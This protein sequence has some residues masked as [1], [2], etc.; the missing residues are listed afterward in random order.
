[1]EEYKG[2]QHVVRT[3][4]KLPDYHLVIAGRG[5]YKEELER[6]A[7][8]EGVCERVELL[9][10]VDDDRLPKLYVGADVYLTLSEFEA[11]G[12]TV[13]EA[14]TARTPCIVRRAGALVDWED[15]PTC[16]GISSVNA[17]AVAKAIKKVQWS[18]DS[19]VP[20]HDWESIIKQYNALY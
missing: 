18:E 10:Y 7:R 3:L 20:I 9:G 13:A 17:T 14:L 16:I 19:S 4:P 12:M 11:Y 8:E 6:I 5:P 15:P 1:L 2:I